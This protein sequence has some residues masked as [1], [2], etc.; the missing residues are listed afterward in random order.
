[1][2]ETLKKS[3]PKPIKSGGRL[4]YD[5]LNTRLSQL[6]HDYDVKFKQKNPMIPP[7]A[8]VFVGK[9][10]FIEIGEEFLHH[11][12]KIGGLKPADRVLDVGCGIGRMAIP[13]TDFL[14]EGSYEGFDIVPVGIKWCQEKITKKYPNFN[15]QLAD[16]YNKIY[17]REGKYKAAEYV[18]PYRDNEFDFIFL[19][20]VFT[21][22]LPPDMENYLAEIAR[23]AKKDGACFITYF[24]LNDE[25]RSKIESGSSTLDFKYERDGCLMVSEEF[26]ESA[27]AFEEQFV[28]DLF[29][30]YGLKINEPVHHGSWSG[31]KDFLTYQDVIVAEK[32]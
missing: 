29:G 15:F 3:V 10:N 2:R 16:I 12:T 14:T 24:L 31:R 30:K 17:H 4:L 18:F 27:I 32:L 21:H 26:P 5:L 9:G 28:K 1:M 13:L 20:S 23:V 8:L 6:K 25:S 19:T 22:L 11:F 7:D